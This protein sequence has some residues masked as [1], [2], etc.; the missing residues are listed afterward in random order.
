MEA[1][2]KWFRIKVMK[3]HVVPLFRHI[4]QLLHFGHHI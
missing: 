4:L 1:E 3:I 2:N